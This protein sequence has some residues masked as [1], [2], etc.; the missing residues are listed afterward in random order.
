MNEDLYQI[1]ERMQI[2]PSIDRAAKVAGTLG[3]CPYSHYNSAKRT[4]IIG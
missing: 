3:P 4:K 2:A 1:I